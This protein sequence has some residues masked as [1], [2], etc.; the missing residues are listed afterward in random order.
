[1]ILHQ[2]QESK[3]LANPRMDHL[4]ELLEKLSKAYSILMLA[5]EI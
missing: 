2:V 5:L 1:M 3:T 4:K